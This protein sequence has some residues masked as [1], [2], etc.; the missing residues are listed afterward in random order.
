V[1]PNESGQRIEIHSDWARDE[2]S[3]ALTQPQQPGRQAAR[4]QGRKA[5]QRRVALAQYVLCIQ[6]NKTP[7]QL[8]SGGG[9]LRA[10][11]EQEGSMTCHSPSSQLVRNFIADTGD[12]Q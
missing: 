4:L 11:C 12:I 2:T 3:R 6:S 10:E 1:R 9:L 7:A 5:W 8:Q